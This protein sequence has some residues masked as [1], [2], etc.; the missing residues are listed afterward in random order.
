MRISNSVSP[1]PT[2]QAL[3]LVPSSASPPSAP[4]G[5]GRSFREVFAE[6]LGRVAE[7]E[8]VLERSLV[9]SMRSRK[10]GSHRGVPF[11]PNWTDDEEG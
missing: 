5:V 1:F 4:T 7:G 11:A 6:T 9:A 3:H 10:W 8:R 2:S